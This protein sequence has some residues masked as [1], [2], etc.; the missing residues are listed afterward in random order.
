MPSEYARGI[1]AGPDGKSRPEAVAEDLAHL[2]SSVVSYQVWRRATAES[3]PYKERDL[4]R[5]T[6]GEPLQLRD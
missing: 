4:V 2:N 6:V 3:Q 5:M 1:F